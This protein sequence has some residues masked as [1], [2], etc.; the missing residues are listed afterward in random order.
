MASRVLVN[1]VGLAHER[2]ILD[3]SGPMPFDNFRPLV[4]VN[5]ISRGRSD[6]TKDVQRGKR[7]RLCFRLCRAGRIVS[8]TLR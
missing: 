8:K 1:C 6:G 7:R 2:P 3:D 4:E 5:L